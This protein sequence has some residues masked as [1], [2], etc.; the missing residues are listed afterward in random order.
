MGT[1]A[2]PA[3]AASATPAPAAEREASPTSRRIDE[4]MEELRSRHGSLE[5]ALRFLTTENFNHRVRSRR[6][7]ARIT[8]LEA[9]VPAAGAVVLT[10]DDAKAFA[11]FKELK[12]SAADVKARIE[13][14]TKLEG[15][16][17]KAEDE[18]A[19]GV[20]AT[21]LK[22]KAS[23]LSKLLAANAPGA[24]VIVK[25]TNVRKADGS[26]IE[27]VEEAFVRTGEGDAAILEPAK[28]FI[29]RSIDKELLD[30]IKD[31]GSTA[32][33]TAAASAGRSN[34][35]PARMPSQSA[36]AKAEGGGKADT[37]A[38]VDRTLQSRYVRPSKRGSAGAQGGA[39]SSG[40][41]E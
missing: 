3:P 26:G 5:N 20:A 13:K 18:R 35:A 29:E 7:K 40:R 10:G 17:A 21:A 28:S 11:D 22:L 16:L 14:A 24:K 31:A 41:N 25:K 2:T 9:K 1:S 27:E 23:P 12:L 32:K 4:A 6:H 36:A 15:D 8:E 34:T 30:A 37:G 39:D 33:G 38:A 19:L